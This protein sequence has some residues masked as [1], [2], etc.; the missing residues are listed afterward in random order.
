MSRATST[1]AQDPTRASAYHRFRTPIH[2]L[3]LTLLGLL[4]Y[5]NT[6]HSPFVFDDMSSIVDNTVI[7]DLSRFLSGEGRAFNPR[8]VVGYF[9]FALNYRLGGLDTLGYHLVNISVHILAG[10][11]VYFLAQVTLSTPF[12]GPRRRDDLLSLVPLFA[13]LLFVAHPVQTQAVTYIVQRLASLVTLFYLL[14]LFCYAKG[15]LSLA[16]A[17]PAGSSASLRANG[18]LRPALFFLGALFFALLALQTKEVAATLPLAILLYEFC[19]FEPSRKRNLILVAGLVVFAL[20]VLTA[21]L[22]AGKPLGELL[23]DV[24]ELSRETSAISR[25]EYL[26]TQFS[27]IATYLRLLFL[28]VNQNLDY[29]YPVYHSLFA[30]QVFFSLLLLVGLFAAALLQQRLSSRCGFDSATSA[31]DD[32]LLKA[33]L[34]RLIAFGIFWFFITLSV[35]SSVIPISDVIFE[36][37]LYL[38]AVGAFT[39]LAAFAIL[40]CR[41]A[42]ARGIAVGIAVAALVFG[43]IT[44]QRNKVWE[45]PVSLWGDVVSKSPTKSRANDHYGV[46]LSGVG[47][48]G[49][50]IEF[51]KT[52][53]QINPRN[54]YALYNLGRLFDETNNIDA[55]I[56]CYE[57]AIELKP[58]LDLAYNNLAVDYLLKGDDDRAIQ[59]YN[60]VLKHKPEFAEAHNNLG[61]ALQ[62][63][64]KVDEAIEQYQAAIRE[65]PGYAKA[66]NN[67]GEAYRAKGELDQAIGQFREALR[68]K[69]EDEA[70]RE[71]LAK[72][73]QQKGV[74]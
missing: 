22:K 2:L 65:N 16:G 52:A 13:A 27:V 19:F 43:G 8:R 12:F 69:P 63:K 25:G 21:V 34:G 62:R 71:N 35:E 68:L 10:W 50:A 44:W 36:H 49:E 74:L 33:R 26:L 53:L 64:G 40:L 29:D 61:F 67:L 38:P 30:P 20:L 1:A 54:E 45:S 6:L 31:S 32:Q 39:A 23:S 5:S 42:S 60:I 72:A 70:A 41:K 47:R 15:R 73:L 56:G 37:R 4:A 46:A 28:P 58:D 14:S 18:Y 11:M 9:T 48:T 55:A 3:L 7:R 66:Y 57:A 17:A 59:C 51:L 24:N